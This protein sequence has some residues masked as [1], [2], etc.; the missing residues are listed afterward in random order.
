MNPEFTAVEGKYEVDKGWSITLP[1]KFNRRTDEGDLVLWRP[2][3]T[4]WIAVWNNDR[5]ETQTS[6]T[7]WL[8]REMPNAAY[9]VIREETETILRFAYRLREATAD[10]RVPAFYGFVIGKAT[11]VQLAVYFDS[12]DD[13]GTASGLW[14]SLK[15]T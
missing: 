10:D 11:H 6:R 15:E 4:A 14:R 3:I 5:G 9:D 8:M 12:E 7:E 2:G 13:L 1:G